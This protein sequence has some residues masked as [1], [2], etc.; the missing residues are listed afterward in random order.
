MVP[1]EQADQKFAMEQTVTRAVR[2]GEIERSDGGAEFSERRGH[3]DNMLYHKRLLSSFFACHYCS[4][5]VDSRLN[6][7]GTGKA[8]GIDA[9]I[10]AFVLLGVF[11]LIWSLYYNSQRDLDAGRSGG[12]DSGMSL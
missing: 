8:L 11:T 5:Q 1:L 7:D 2:G 9:G 3:H 4:L 10:E 12:D 6:G